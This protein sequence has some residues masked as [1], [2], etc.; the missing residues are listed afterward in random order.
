MKIS[1][2]LMPNFKII[3]I[4]TTIL[5]LTFR[6]NSS[7]QGI[8]IDTLLLPKGEKFNHFQNDKLKFPIIKTGNLE[9]DKLVNKDLKNR[10]TNNEFPDLPTDSTLIKWADEQIIYL[11][12]HVT[13]SKSG[14]VSL[15]I[16]AEGC[17]AYCTGWTDYF[18]YNLTTG[19]HVTINEIVD[20]TSQFKILVLSDKDKQYEEQKAELK[21]MLMDKDSGLDQDTYEWALEYY[22]NCDNE[23]AL[24]SFALYAD[25]L[26]IISICHLPNAIKNLTPIIELKYDY[27]SI[28]KYL[29]IKN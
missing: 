23:F 20:T 1:L 10:F 6:L 16:T 27:M 7:G 22:D 8:S 4:L 26:E 14:L 12:F 3:R 21:K 29:K 5:I 24:N 19:K 28:K 17:G 15:N 13:Y 11:D 18:T 25:H 2:E 9:I